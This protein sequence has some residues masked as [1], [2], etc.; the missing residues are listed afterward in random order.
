M[1]RLTRIEAL[2]EEQGQ[3]LSDLALGA[4]SS[5]APSRSSLQPMPSPSLVSASPASATSRTLEGH[6][7]HADQAQFLIP[8]DHNTAA[9]SLLSLP[10]VRSLAGDYPKSYFYDIEETFPLPPP[11]DLIHQDPIAWP[12]APDPGTLE[13]LTDVYFAAVHPTY[14]LFTRQY[15]KSL[16]SSVLENGL[17]ETPETAICLCV[18][19][20][21]CIFVSSTTPSARPPRDFDGLGLVF[22]K[23]ALRL[24]LSRTVWGFTPDVQICQA[25]LLAASYIAHLGRP[26]HS[27]KMVHYASHKFL[28]LTHKYV[29]TTF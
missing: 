8:Y 11:L 12:P 16:Y 25:L 17:T 20:L 23:P 15:F 27:W 21:G 29:C 7:I 4:E 24:I 28:Q 10:I 26:L 3:R 18:W 1:E 2:L 6:D 22:F 14:P 5:Y 9:V 13:L 19:A